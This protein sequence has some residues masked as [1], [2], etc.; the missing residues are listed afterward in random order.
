[1]TSRRRVMGLAAAALAAPRV[2]RA[3][4]LLDVEVAVIGAG[5]AGIAATTRLAAWGYDILL[6]EARERVGGRAWTHAGPLGLPWD[7]GAMWLHNGRANPLRPL[8]RA[9]GLTLT[10]SHYEDLRVSGAATPPGDAGEALIAA[11][12]R[13]GPRIDAAVSRSAPGATLATL[14]NGDRIET[15]ALALAAL[16]IGGDPA[17]VSLR[18]AAMQDSGE[19]ALVAGG[20]GGLL[21]M[22]AAGLPML[23]GH[24]VTAI[25]MRAAG[26]VAVSGGFGT[27]RAGAVVLTVP[28]PVLATGAIRF[29]PE[30]PERKG[31]ALAALGPAEFLKVGLRLPH[32]REDVP[33]FAVDIPAFV[34]GEG[35]LLHIDPRAPLASVLFA[36]AH[37][38]ALAAAGPRAAAAAASA[39]LR[40]HT[41]IG[42]LVADSHDWDA[43]PFSRGPWVRLRPGADTA[44]ADYVTPVDDRLFFAG[45][46]AP[47]PLA[48][49]L[50][51][52]WQSG[53]DAADAIWAAT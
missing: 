42:A 29:T 5:A 46:A 11:L 8:A 39:V 7:R 40:D 30:L 22:L 27:L 17:Q 48:T 21:R 37:A 33:E 34:A 44:R 16:A 36:G 49:T 31:A 12:D 43:D 51:G 53:L 1:M 4:P 3:D 25:D 18:D 9:A 6:L 45:E 38:T 2:L 19:D 41:G 14:T 24:A 23:T 10:R 50:G 35:A 28:P 13:L 20:P 32:T 52:A 26:H 47:G 15:A